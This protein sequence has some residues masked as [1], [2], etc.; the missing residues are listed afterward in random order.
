MLH[1]NERIPLS[2]WL[3]C[4]VQLWQFPAGSLP[5]P[6]E[7]VFS[8]SPGSSAEGAEANLETY[9]RLCKHFLHYRLDVSKLGVSRRSFPI[10]YDSLPLLFKES[11]V[12]SSPFVLL[13]TL[14][15]WDRR[16]GCAHRA[17]GLVEAICLFFTWFLSFQQELQQISPAIYRR[18]CHLEATD[19]A[20][21]E[22]L[23][24]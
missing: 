5:K 15:G 22:L 8:T 11:H 7:W 18:K 3:S 17:Q 21:R 4:W 23:T 1:Q 12:S 9:G 16:K 13:L 20:V 19:H 14:P 10:W 24:G 2:Q 6:P